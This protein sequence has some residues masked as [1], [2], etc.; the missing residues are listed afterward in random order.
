VAVR[1]PVIGVHSSRHPREDPSDWLCF[2]ALLS[3]AMTAPCN[4]LKFALKSP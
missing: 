1:C 4:V 2:G 3:K